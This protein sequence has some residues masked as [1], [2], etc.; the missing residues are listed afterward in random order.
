MRGKVAVKQDFVP[1]TAACTA[2]KPVRIS[3]EQDMTGPDEKYG[4][5]CRNAAFFDTGI[6]GDDGV[7]IHTDNIALC[8]PLRNGNGKQGLFHVMSDLFG[9][10]KKLRGGIF[11]VMYEIMPGAAGVIQDVCRIGRAKF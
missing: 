2:K 9:G 6:R 10:C 1:K 3:G 8:I 4:H 5:T 7:F 11:E